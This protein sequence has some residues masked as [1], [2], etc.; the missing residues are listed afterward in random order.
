MADDEV[1]RLAARLSARPAREPRHLPG[2]PF[3]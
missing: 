1:E 2:V 3:S